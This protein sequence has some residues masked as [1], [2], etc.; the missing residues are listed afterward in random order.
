MNR[1]KLTAHVNIYILEVIS[2]ELLYAQLEIYFEF[3]T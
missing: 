1:Y 2:Y 3:G